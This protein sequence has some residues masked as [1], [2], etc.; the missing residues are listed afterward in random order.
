MSTYRLHDSLGFRLSRAARIQERRLDEG[1]RR[2]GLTRTT[3]CLLLGVGNEGLSQPSE[4]AD[5][6]GIDRTAT[7]R[8]LRQMEADGLVSRQTGEGDGRTR[9]VVLTDRGRAALDAGTPLAVANNA[10]MAA[11]LEEGEL[12]ALKELLDRL[13]AGQPALPRL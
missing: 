2:L 10:E 5:F 6:V 12:G 13:I 4:L 8:A 3:W 7:S 11:R 1:L 9:A